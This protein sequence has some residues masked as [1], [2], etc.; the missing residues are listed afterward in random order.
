MVPILLPH[1]WMDVVRT[2]LL[3]SD[4]CQ[5]VFLR[6]SCDHFTQG[7]KS[8]SFQH[9]KS[10]ERTQGETFERQPPSDEHRM[11]SF[12]FLRRLCVSYKNSVDV[13]GS[14]PSLGEPLRCVCGFGKY[15]FHSS[16]F[17][18][19]FESIFLLCV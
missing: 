14:R 8:T 7:F 5:F 9:I 17:P 1:L 2:A 11:C 16:T 18:S 13:L 12:N 3:N 6:G 10:V 4:Y 15:C 19:R